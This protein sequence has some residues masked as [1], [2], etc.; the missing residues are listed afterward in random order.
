MVRLISILLILFPCWQIPRSKEKAPF[1]PYGSLHWRPD[2][3]AFME[4]WY[5]NALERV[6]E[7]SLNRAARDKKRHVYRFL[8]LRSFHPPVAI[9]IEITGD[10]TGNLVG[11]QLDGR[12]GYDFGRRITET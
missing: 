8:W 4:S 2:L 6:N 5:S 11:K 1:F 10:G 3:D 12:G 9:R 7:R